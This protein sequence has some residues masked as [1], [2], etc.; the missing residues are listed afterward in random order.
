MT[1][2][3]MTTETTTTPPRAVALPTGEYPLSTL[4]LRLDIDGVS[5]S[6]TLR[7]D[8]SDVASRLPRVLDYIKRLQAKLPKTEPAPATETPRPTAVPAREI[9]DCEWHGP[10]KES[11]KTPGTFYCPKRMAN[12]EFCKE[13]RPKRA[14]EK[15][16]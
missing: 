8:D 4:S 2:V 11:T 6:W 1:D 7:G 15:S 5:L 9:H 13:R 3:T 12:G 16:A 10:M 14:G